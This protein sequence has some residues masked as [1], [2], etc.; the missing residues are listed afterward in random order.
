MFTR[1]FWR[2]VRQAIE[3]E[4]QTVRLIAIFLTIG[5]IALIAYLIA[6]R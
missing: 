5:A 2:T 6:V 1:E 3:K 4:N